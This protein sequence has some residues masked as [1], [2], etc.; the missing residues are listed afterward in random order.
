MKGLLKRDKI[1]WIDFQHNGVRYRKSCVT[2]SRKKAEEIFCK[3]KTQILEGRFFEVKARETT[4]EELREGLL[5]DYKIN[6][7][8]SM[9]RLQRSLAHLNSFFAGYLAVD[10]TTDIVKSYIVMR[11][12]TGAANATIN[13][14]LAALKRMLNLGHRCT[15]PRII[16]V[17]YIP[18]LEENNIRQGYFSHEEFYNLRKLLP[19]YIQPVVTMAYYTGMRKEE[20]LGLKWEQVNLKERMITL[21]PQ[22][23]KNKEGRVIFMP[24][25]LLKVMQNQRLFRN[26]QYPDTCWVFFGETGARIKDFRF[27]W[28]KV[29]KKAGLEGRLFHDFRRTAVRNMIRAGIPEKVVMSISG[30]KTRSVFE[31]Y[32]IINEDDL[33]LAAEKM[34]SM[35]PEEKCHNSVTIDETRAGLSVTTEPPKVPILKLIQ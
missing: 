31:R 18:M 35:M 34:H 3:I 8:K 11:Q 15:P 7:K 26:T 2:S 10:I 1:W 6:K 29:C 9:D 12:D 14:E 21:K 33:R 20:I 28:K 23:T 5:V 17:P 19:D 13:R 30:H 4:Y 32:N 25:E 22:D 27:V 16:H 24:N